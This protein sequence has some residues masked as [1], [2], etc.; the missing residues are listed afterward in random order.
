MCVARG[1]PFAIVAHGNFSWPS[2]ELAARY[3]KALPLARG[4]F[5]V[6]EANRVLA[7]RQLG[8]SIDNAEI[9]RNPLTIEND[10]PM[11]WPV[12][13]SDHELCMAC[14]GRLDPHTKGQDI[15]LDVLAASNW[16]DR[17]WRLTF[18]GNGPNREVL[19]RL[20]K[21]LKLQDRV[22]FAG[23]VAV[24]KVWRDNHLLVMPSRSEAMP[25]A[26]VEAM[27]SGRPVVATNVG[28]IPEIIKDGLTGF[29][30]EAAVAQCFGRALERMWEQRDRLQEM[31]K[32]AAADIREFMPHDPVGIF[33]GKIRDMA[34]LQR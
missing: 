6:S 27:L 12:V 33:A 18:C 4:Y 19:E 9:V 2:D 10:F 23:H 28:G 5:F 7:E 20:V 34:S 26:V 3:R 21:S 30:A 14:V 1:W 32:L 16:A 22:S 8:H 13:T 17:N 25:L 31:G 15:L 11:P 29:L 24:E